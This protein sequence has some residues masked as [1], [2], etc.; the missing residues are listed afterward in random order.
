MRKAKFLIV[1]VVVALALVG[2]A[3]AAWSTNLYINGTVNTATFSATI[4]PNGSP[5][6]NSY[7]GQPLVTSSQG[8]DQQHLTVAVTNMYPGYSATIPYKITINNSIPATLDQ[9]IQFSTDGGNTWQNISNAPDWLGVSTLVK[10]DQ[11]NT[12]NFQYTVPVSTSPNVFTGTLTIQMPS[13][14]TGTDGEG[15]NVQVQI[16]YPVNQKTS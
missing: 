12:V 8:A 5:T 13:S 7:T 9:S 16:T 2:A 4:V 10:D 3:Y 6:D 14:V 11:G 15:Q 1:A